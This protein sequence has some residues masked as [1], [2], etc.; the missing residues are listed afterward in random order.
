VDTGLHSLHWTRQ[1]AIDY[2]IPA[3]EVDRYVVWPGQACAYMLGRLKIEA[4]RDKARA[5]LGEKFDIKKF[6]NLVLLTGNVP[7]QVL[8][9]VVDDWIKTQRAQK[10]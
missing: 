9:D 10:A 6:H 2:G 4:L 3:T 5:A 7:L 8:E 1:Q